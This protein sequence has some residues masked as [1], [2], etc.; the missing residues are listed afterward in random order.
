MILYANYFI[1]IISVLVLSTAL[2]EKYFGIASCIKKF[3]IFCQ[4][5]H[6]VGVEGRKLN[7]R[8]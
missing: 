7:E 4:Q 2:S 8:I 5:E 1:V 3:E 6:I